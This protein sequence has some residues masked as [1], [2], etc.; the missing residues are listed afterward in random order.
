MV[1]EDLVPMA[2]ELMAK[3][4]AKGVHF[5]LPTD[6]VVADKV[7][8]RGRANPPPFMRATACAQGTF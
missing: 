7:S 2:A 3:A 6:V 8:S 1:G 4:K 5:Y